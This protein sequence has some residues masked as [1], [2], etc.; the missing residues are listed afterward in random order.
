MSTQTWDLAN[1]PSELARAHSRIHVLEEENFDLRHRLEETARARLHDYVLSGRGS[2]RWPDT[3][4]RARPVDELRC[5]LC[6][7]S[8][9][10]SVPSEAGSIGTARCSRS[11][12]ETQYGSR[13]NDCPWTGTKLARLADRSVV[14]LWPVQTGRRA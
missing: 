10:W 6:D 7:S 4:D 11:P 8:V 14:A 1:P 13:R 3:I 9:N 2:Y 12:S 5:P